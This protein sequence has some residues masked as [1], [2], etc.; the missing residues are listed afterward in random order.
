M[1]S[2]SAKGLHSCCF[3]PALMLHPAVSTDNRL[4]TR[5]EPR[6]GWTSCLWFHQTL[7]LCLHQLV[8]SRRSSTNM[9]LLVCFEPQVW[10]SSPSSR[11]LPSAL[12]KNTEQINEGTDLLLCDCGKS[13]GTG[14]GAGK[15]RRWFW[16][17][18]VCARMI[19]LTNTL[20]M[21]GLQTVEST[22]YL[23]VQLCQVF[24]ME[25]SRWVLHSMKRFLWKV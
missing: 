4:Q 23:L 18:D 22:F 13:L 2:L 5:F 17:G 3:R 9:K 8:L 15:T 7:S 21:F 25:L 24:S 19:W 12:P 11:S 14:T 16:G 6:S 10:R 1:E 20:Y